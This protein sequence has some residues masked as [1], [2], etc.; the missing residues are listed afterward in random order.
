MTQYLNSYKKRLEIAFNP[1]AIGFTKSDK[2]LVLLGLTPNKNGLIYDQLVFNL[3]I[4][5]IDKLNDFVGGMYVPP[6]LRRQCV[7]HCLKYI[8][9]GQLNLF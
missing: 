1:N 2:M 5:E 4:S 7:K 3:S 8:N 9:L 6:Q